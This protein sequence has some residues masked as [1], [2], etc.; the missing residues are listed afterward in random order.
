MITCI[1]KY[2]QHLVTHRDKIQPVLNLPHIK[3][4]QRLQ[5][6][7]TQLNLLMGKILVIIENTLKY[8]TTGGKWIYFQQYLG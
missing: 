8:L 4:F 7:K 3:I 5:N 1:V 2:E 6:L